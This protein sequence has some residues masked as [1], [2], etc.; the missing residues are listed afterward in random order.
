M[1]KRDLIDRVRESGGKITIGNIDE[2][3]QRATEF[4]GKLIIIKE[5]SIHEVVNAD[6]IDPQRTNVAIPNT[7]QKP[8]LDIGTE[9]ELVARTFLTAA[10]LF[11]KKYFDEAVDTQRVLK[12]SFE[13]LQELVVLEKEINEYLTDE[14]DTANAYNER[15]KVPAPYTLPTITNLVTRCKTIFQKADHI[16][17]T[18][19]DIARLFY[20]SDGLK[21][22]GHFE[23]FAGLVAEK[24]GESDDFSKFLLHSVYTMRVIRYV[25]DGLDHRG[26]SVKVKDFALQLDSTITSPTIEL[27]NK[28]ERLSETLLSSFLPTLLSRIIAVVEGTIVCLAEKH[29]KSSFIPYEIREIPVEKRKYRLTRFSF[30]S[31]TPVNDDG[32]YHQ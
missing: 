16:N 4:D 27:V 1:S 28:H 3:I 15:I 7:I 21:K 22:Q 2:A 32:F 31:P 14:K 5:N 25:R 29:V 8:I 17:Q 6:F 9:S 18:M 10:L 26:E 23:T 19:I 24:Y 12:L 13:L 11:E 20:S 30:W